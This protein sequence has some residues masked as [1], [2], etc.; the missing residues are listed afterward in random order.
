ME[1]AALLLS[2]LLLSLCALFGLLCDATWSFTA[3][4]LTAA[5]AL[6]ADTVAGAATPYL[7]LH[8]CWKLS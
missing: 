2:A 1:T 4:L 6:S 5:M 3:K 7:I 8:A